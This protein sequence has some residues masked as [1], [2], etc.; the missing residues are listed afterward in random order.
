MASSYFT[1]SAWIHDGKTGQVST[2]HFN[3]PCGTRVQSGVYADGENHRCPN[4][5][6][7][8]DS[9]GWIL[10][11][12][13]PGFK[14]AKQFQVEPYGDK[15]GIRLWNVRDTKSGRLTAIGVGTKR[16]AEEIAQTANRGG[17]PGSAPLHPGQYGQPRSKS[18]CDSCERTH[19]GPD[20]I[21]LT[22]VDVDG[23]KMSLCEFCRERPELAAAWN[24]LHHDH[25][26]HG[27]TKNRTLR[28]QGVR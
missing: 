6:R 21:H 14:R 7:L 2:G 24:K 9:K 25:A 28:R 19:A 13:K 20:R 5:G 8:Y 23:K 10:E 16:H 27:R 3:C 18:I 17:Y 12:P 4:C 11:G 22:E 15:P 26:G 1:K